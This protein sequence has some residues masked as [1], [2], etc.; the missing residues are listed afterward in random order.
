MEGSR[1]NKRRRQP[2]HVRANAA[3]WHCRAEQPSQGTEALGNKSKSRYFPSG[4]PAPVPSPGSR[5]PPRG[6]KPR[7]PRPFLGS[8]KGS[9]SRGTSG[10]RP[11]S[12]VRSPEMAPQ[13][14]GS[15]SAQLQGSAPAFAARVLAP[16]PQIHFSRGTHATFSPQSLCTT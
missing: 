7:Q 8:S 12:L 1:R 11:Q 14:A 13:A 6:A 9:L 5:A 4:E 2:E 15:L 10:S 16:L 3:A